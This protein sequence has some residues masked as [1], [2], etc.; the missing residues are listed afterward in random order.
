MKEI[1]DVLFLVDDKEILDD[2]L[3]ELNEL[4][5]LLKKSISI[6][7]IYSVGTAGS[8]VS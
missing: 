7:V 1:K 2:T 4:K 6:R 5:L 8:Q 3:E